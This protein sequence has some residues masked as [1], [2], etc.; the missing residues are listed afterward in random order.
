M[1]YM[2]LLRRLFC[3]HEYEG[4]Q[5]IYGEEI[6]MVGGKRSW[7]RCRKCG[8]YQLRDQL[9]EEDPV[10]TWIY[11]LHTEQ[12]VSDG[13]KEIY[14]RMVDGLDKQEDLI[15]DDGWT[16]ESMRFDKIAQLQRGAMVELQM[17]NAKLRMQN[18]GLTTKAERQ[19]AELTKL[20]L[21]LEQRNSELRCY[22]AQSGRLARDMGK[23]R[24]Q[25]R[26]LRETVHDAWMLLDNRWNC[27][28]CPRSEECDGCE[29][30]VRKS[31]MERMAKHGIKVDE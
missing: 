5:N 7:W 16:V 13:A 8:K 21:A 30:L 18:E 3:R 10:T 28:Y 24:E 19:A 1:R 4:D 12:E 2:S 17:E 20:R 23:L 25:N 22:K 6:N 9:Y 14:D 26:E 29:C 11:D 31:I 27:M 15:S